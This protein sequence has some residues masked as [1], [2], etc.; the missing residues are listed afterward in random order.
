M[1]FNRLKATGII[2][3][4]LLPVFASVA[5]L[6]AS[7]RL[8]RIVPPTAEPGDQVLAV[9]ESFGTY[10]KPQGR[11]EAESASSVRLVNIGT[12]GQKLLL[13]CEILS[14]EDT[15]VLFTL[16]EDARMIKRIGDDGF[17]VSDTLLFYS[18]ESSSPLKLPY[19]VSESED[20][21]VDNLEVVNITA[22]SAIVRWRSSGWGPDSLILAL[23]MYD[24]LDITSA[25]FTDQRN[26][27]P[28]F[29][30]K[31]SGR[32][33]SKT[34]SAS[35]FHS[36]LGLKNG[37]HQVVLTGLHPDRL[38]RFFIALPEERFLVDSTRF[39]GGPYTPVLVGRTADNH[40]GL[41]DAFA[42][43]TLAD[44][45]SA[46]PGYVL[47]GSVAA[48]VIGGRV[49]IFL[50]SRAQPADTSTTVGALL[51][52]QGRWI[53]NL[54]SLRFARQPSQHFFP[55]EGDFISV[56]VDAGNQ[57]FCRFEASFGGPNEWIQDLGRQVLQ[58]VVD[59]P[60]PIYP[61][62][63]L[64]S[65][66]VEY[67]DNR[68][69]TAVFQ[70]EKVPGGNAGL[71]R[72]LTDQ[73]L[74]QTCFRSGM[75]GDRYLGEN[76]ILS[77]GQAYIL[78]S[79]H[80]SDLIWRGAMFGDNLPEIV[81]PGA[82]LFY[83]SRPL[84]PDSLSFSW[85]SYSFLQQVDAA[86]EIFTWDNRRQS[87][88]SAFKI[89][90]G[91]VWGQFFTL[92]PGGGYI[93]RITEASSWNAA[94]P[95]QA[96]LAGRSAA[97]IPQ[98]A[99]E[100]HRVVQPSD[101]LWQPWPER[102]ILCDITASSFSLLHRSS[103]TAIHVPNLPAGA[104]SEVFHR[105]EYEL[106]VFSG[107]LPGSE[108]RLPGPGALTFP[109]PNNLLPPRPDLICYGT[110]SDSRGFPL[111]GRPVWL[112]TRGG[113]LL[114]TFSDGEGNWWINLANLPLKSSEIKNARDSLALRV[115]TALGNNL[116]QAGIRLRDNFPAR[117]DLELDTA[118][119]ER[120]S[121]LGTA[122]GSILP[123]AFSLEQ[124]NP[125]PFNPGT[126][127]AFTVPSST[128]EN[129]SVRLEV[130]NLRG[131]KVKTLIEESLTAGRYSVT[132]NG[133]DEQDRPLGSGVYFY[134]L[135]LPEACL[136]RKMILLK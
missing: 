36:E 31:S 28:N 27:Y 5:G 87:Y 42:F 96:V 17:P 129:R 21:Q 38:Y 3:L 26:Y 116:L 102:P 55:E 60:E 132:W 108:V 105:A 24:S 53:V 77:P 117:L 123:R 22:T 51:D 57:G 62:I 118:A 13:D 133:R 18:A 66:P 106:V 65:V 34:S 63:N 44:L 35:V 30:V 9:G 67:F 89:P 99:A 70:L 52:T 45:G 119:P 49:T 50:V 29:V 19:L 78:S 107:L 69:L 91:E 93:A 103:F 11:A 8:M 121:C 23:G 84:Q 80:K 47:T 79:S 114:L 120:F 95:D 128:G 90:G 15:R 58:A 112:G 75:P 72:Y 61:G 126:S 85:D 122:S 113:D 6:S 101:W 7:P 41:F 125:N 100:N 43:R 110:L 98:P 56:A 33:S 48:H 115:T 59:F 97:P 86:K 71:S 135:S 54:S 94:L 82:G 73:G 131:Q 20:F 40:N 25:F 74:F 32:L 14:W 83:F 68:P 136:T 12:D 124:N 81:F 37:I 10:L 64:F 109:L 127:I 76:F 111:A 39:V 130:F 92:R 16:P 104:G 2:L 4:A 134:R 1:D 46:N 88:L